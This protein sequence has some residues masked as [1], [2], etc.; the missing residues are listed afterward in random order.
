MTDIVLTFNSETNPKTI[1]I[2][3]LTRNGDKWHNNQNIIAIFRGDFE[4]CLE[5]RYI[6][7][8]NIIEILLRHNDNANM[9]VRLAICES[10]HIHTGY[11]SHDG[12]FVSQQHTF[13]DIESPVA[14]FS[15]DVVF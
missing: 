8:N 13:A 4:T 2:S 12:E 3:G 7:H 10:L 14:T 9:I 11:W 15:G 6:C 5:N 1:T